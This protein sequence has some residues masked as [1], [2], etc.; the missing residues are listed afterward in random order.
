M[1]SLLR[2]RGGLLAVALFVPASAAQ[3]APAPDENAVK[4]DKYLPD[5]TGG[6]FVVDVKQILASKTFTK[7]LKKQVE[8]LLK[9]DQ[10]QMVLKDTGFDPLKD[11]DRVVLAI[12]PGAEGMSGPFLLVEGRFDA[13]KLTAKAADLAKQFPIIKE[14]EIGKTKAYELGLPGQ[15]AY[16]A[17]VDKGVFVLSASKPEMAETIEKAGGKRK[18]EFKSKSLAKLIAK[19]DPQ[20]AVNVA[21]AGEMPTGGS[22][23]SVPGG[24]I[25]RMV[26]TL[27]DEG[28]DAVT[29]GVSVGED[30]KGKIHFTTR[31]ADTAKKLAAEF[32][33]GLARM[34]EEIAREAVRNKDLAP[35]V[36]VVKTIK[37][38]VNEQTIT[39][40]G[41]GTAASV[42]AFIKAMFFEF[43]RAETPVPPPPAPAKAIPPPPAPGK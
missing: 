6:V 17:L 29:G 23:R 25:V 35:V 21:C 22:A 42:E 41:K 10:V 9:L 38:S 14:I 5:D 2:L 37:S 43:G 18:T 28:I 31:D 8:E 3:A 16:V 27:A 15:P 7:E 24:G 32:E 33:V 13:A 12:T 34:H 19:M 1:S 40:E 30:I 20:L 39:T 4:I 11:I 36:E 26:R